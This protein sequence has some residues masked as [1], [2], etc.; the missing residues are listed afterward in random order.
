VASERSAPQPTSD[1][2][3]RRHAILNKLFSELE[4]SGGELSETDRGICVDIDGEK[5]EFQI[6]EKNRQ[7]RLTPTGPNSYPS[8]ELVGTGKL[9]FAIRTYLRDR[10]NEEWIETDTNPLENRLPQI[11]NRLFDGARILSEWHA[12]LKAAEELRQRQ[13][14]EREERRRLALQEQ[15]RR[16]RLRDIAGDWR[17]ANEIRNLIAAMKSQAYDGEK[18]IHGKS[19]AEWFK[20]ADA[21]AT[22]LDVT[23]QGPEGLFSIVGSTI[24]SK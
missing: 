6:R 24:A 9:V 19:L 16:V 13:R 1:V 17:A 4:T 22:S 12:E 7:I 20:W 23:S 2:Y 10:R 11:I 18:E 3:R 5:I 14:A 15:G 21:A 8:Q